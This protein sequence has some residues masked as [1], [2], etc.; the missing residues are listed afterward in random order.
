[1]TLLSRLTGVVVQRMVGAHLGLSN[2]SD[3][4]QIAYRLP[5]ML[6]RF[7][8]EGTMTAAFLPTLVDIDTKQGEAQAKKFVAD[9]LGTLCAIL[10]VICAVGVLLMT[11]ITALLMLGK[12]PGTGFLAQLEFMWGVLLGKEN[13]PADIALSATLGKIMFPYLLLVSITAA[14]AAVLNMR[15]RFALAASTNMWGNL[16]FIIVSWVA[17]HFMSQP[18]GCRASIVFALALLVHG[19]VQIAILTFPY[20]RMGFRFGCT[21]K[22]SNPDVR[23]ALS[24]MVPGII[25]VGIHPINVVVSQSLAS[26]LGDGAQTVLATSNL[27]GELVLGLFAVSMATVSLPAMSRLASEG[28]L[29]G[30]RSSLGEA[31]RGTALFAIPGS[32][33][34]ALLA[35]P[36]IAMIYHKGAFGAEAVAWTS[37][38]L[39]FQAIGLIFI[40]SARIS[41]QTLNAMKDY[42]GPALAALVAFSC[43]VA[44]SLILMKPMGTN[45][46]AMANSLS[47]F[48]GLGFLAWRLKYTLGRLPIWDVASGWLRM[49]IAATMMGLAAWYGNRLLQINDPHFFIGTLNISLRLFPLIAVC[50]LLYFGLTMLLQV[51]EAKIFAN[52]VYKKLAKKLYRM[53]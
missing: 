37:A 16:A 24:R 31:L 11:P 32:V 41:T 7:T 26:R 15:Q 27:L 25:A 28:N 10:L 20:M 39:P 38:T 14:M 49:G 3:A 9:F 51:P 33:G 52:A 43:N 22:F 21:T 35:T 48:V 12:L 30:L 2:I 42:R 18:H 53:Q 8:A 50:A 17:F 13:L 46:M 23:L 44:F 19:V 5:N 4:Y 40:A 6:R 1:M 29:D 36:I 47:A 45:G 34:M